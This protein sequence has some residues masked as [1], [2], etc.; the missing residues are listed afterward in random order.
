ML[1]K[2]EAFWPPFCICNRPPPAQDSPK[3]TAD[4]HIFCSTEAD[5]PHPGQSEAHRDNVIVRHLRKES[6]QPR[7]TPARPFPVVRIPVPQPGKP[8]W[9][10][11]VPVSQVVQTG[12]RAFGHRYSGMWSGNRTF[13]RTRRIEGGV[14]ERSLPGW[15]PCSCWV[16]AC[17]REK[18]LVRQ[19]QKNPRREFPPGVFLLPR[20][21][22]KQTISFYCSSG[23]QRVIT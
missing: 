19:Q 20:K 2:T 12:G 18:G 16:K 3:H 7:I 11:L 15:S 10:P 21:G 1:N 6:T 4:R 5:I 17:L 22:E 23:R 13:C 14:S 8:D 9:R